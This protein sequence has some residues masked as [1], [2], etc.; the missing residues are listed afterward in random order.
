MDA[1]EGFYRVLLNNN[2]VLFV[3]NDIQ[4]PDAEC[5]R[6]DKE[7]KVFDENDEEMQVHHVEYMDG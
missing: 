1:K 7:G 6:I 2:G 3:D 4:V 5:I